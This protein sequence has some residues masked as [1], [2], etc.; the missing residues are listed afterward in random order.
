MKRPQVTLL[1]RDPHV[2]Y[3]YWEGVS[4][5]TTAVLEALGDDGEIREVERFP[6]GDAEGGRF[7]RFDQPG[8]RH[9][10]RLDG[11]GFRVQ[12]SWLEAPRQQPGDDEPAFVRV[13]WTDDA[14]KIEGQAHHDPALGRFPAG[15][16]PRGSTPTSA[17]HT[18]SGVRR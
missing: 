5:G 1:P 13:Q 17:S 7:V 16:T 11:D 14:V 6:T 12:T 15:K 3:V 2:A 8:A 18:S 9:R 10:C 4:P